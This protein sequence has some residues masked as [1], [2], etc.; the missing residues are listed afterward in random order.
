MMYWRDT[1]LPKVSVIIPSYNHALFIARAV[2]SV[3]SQT[4]SDFELIIVDDGSTDASLSVLAGYTDQRMRVIKQS[5]QGAPSAINRGLQEA[6]GQFIAILNSD[7]EYYPD[8]LEKLIAVLASDTKF[9]L[10]GSYI[11]VID[12][13]NKTLGVKHG[14]MD[15]EPWLLEEPK[16]SFR[17][18]QDLHAALL[19][20][21]YWATTSNYVFRRVRVERLGGFR[22]LRYAHDWDFGLRLARMGKLVLLPEPLLRYRIHSRNTIRENQAA[23]IFE[24]C[25]CLA[26]HL[27]ET[28]ATDWFE[29][30]PAD[31]RVDQLLHSIYTFDLDRVLTVMLLQRL[32]ERPD[33]ALQLLEPDDPCRHQYLEFIQNTLARQSAQAIQPGRVIRRTRIIL[34][35]LRQLRRRDQSK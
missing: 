19:T 22:N 3:L 18:G 26:V 11:E 28:I 2:D 14:Y 27:P 21:N 9:G 35:W 1:R 29:E 13:H 34:D 12:I 25:W 5:N 17:N 10:A 7:D 8:R 16:R 15:L 33:M 31:R 4:E 30:L 23:M 20:E 32:S 6:S 24:I